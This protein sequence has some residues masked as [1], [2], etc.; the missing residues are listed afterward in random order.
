MTRF[1]QKFTKMS[2][3]GFVETDLLR[4]TTILFQENLMHDEFGG[5]NLND[6]DFNEKNFYKVL[7]K[8]AR[9]SIGPME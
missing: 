9:M 2:F 3:N 5:K 1:L 6:L 4:I 7:L 8:K